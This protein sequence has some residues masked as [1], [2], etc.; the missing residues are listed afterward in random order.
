MQF[1]IIYEVGAHKKVSEVQKS[2]AKSHKHECLLFIFFLKK[3]FK[4]LFIPSKKYNNMEKWQAVKGFEDYKISNLGNVYSIKNNKILQVKVN[5]SGWQ[6]VTL[7]KDK[8][9]TRK[10]HRLVAEAFIPN[11]NNYYYV[12]HIDGNRENNKD[13]NLHW[14]KCISNNVKLTQEQVKE[15]YTST[16]SLTEL[17]IRFNV[18]KSYVCMIQKGY[19]RVD[20]TEAL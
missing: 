1:N 2:I 17:S 16:D 14:V 10:V 11:P 19:A 3:F 12:K 7:C 20:I 15:I 9:I 13:T 4:N 5:K 6:T 8:Q 18:S